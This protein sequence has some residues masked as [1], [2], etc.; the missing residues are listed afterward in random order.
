TTSF[1]LLEQGRKVEAASI[2]T[3]VG[4]GAVNAAI[5]MRRLGFEAAALVK[6]G[7]D[8]NATKVIER[9]NAE[10]VATDLVLRSD[11]AGTGT[12]VM[13]ASHDRNAA[14]F[15]ARGTNRLLQDRDIRPE[16]FTGTDVVYV[17]ALSDNSA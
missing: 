15:T 13:V 17:T 10:K 1:L 4:G 6:L 2:T 16:T 5:S 12:A 11:Q 9:L 14:I 7:Q 3:H 8:L